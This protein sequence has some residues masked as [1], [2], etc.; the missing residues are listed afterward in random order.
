MGAI[1]GEFKI[2]TT[3]YGYE[4]CGDVGVVYAKF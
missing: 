1:I 2:P 4:Y 3:E